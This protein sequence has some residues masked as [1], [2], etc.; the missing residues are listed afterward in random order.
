MPLISILLLTNVPEQNRILC[1]AIAQ[2]LIR[3]SR[4]M[5]YK[6][7]MLSREEI[8]QMFSL[9]ELKQTRVYQEALEEGRQEGRQEGEQEGRRKEALSMVLRQLNRRLGALE[10]SVE[11]QVRGLSLARL[12]VLGEALLDFNNASDLQ[13]WLRSRS[14]SERESHDS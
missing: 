8:E 9:S 10:S 7:P 13:D 14:F 6:F 1:R 5:V 12:E 4:T 11:A 3:H 2:G